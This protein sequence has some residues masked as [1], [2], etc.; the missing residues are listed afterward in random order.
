MP[1]STGNESMLHVRLEYKRYTG[2][3][4]HTGV[5]PRSISREVG[6]SRYL[7]APRT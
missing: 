5:I 2:A 1:C 6:V 4:I 7:M 3:A